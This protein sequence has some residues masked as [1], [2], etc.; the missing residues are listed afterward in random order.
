MAAPPD[1][2]EP[3]GAVALTLPQ[4]LDEVTTDATVGPNDSDYN[5]FCGA[6]ATEGSVW[7]TYTP[8]ADGGVLI[9]VSQSDFEAGVMVFDGT[10]AGD[11]SNLD[12][13]GPDEVGLEAQTGT[14]YYIMAF[15]DTADVPHDNLEISLSSAPTPKAHASLSKKGKAF[16]GGAAELHGSYRCTHDDFG[17]E[18]DV[19]LLQ[20]AGRLKIQAD[21]FTLVQCD[22]KTHHWSARLVSDNGYYAKGKA[23]A[24][25]AII[26]CGVVTCAVGKDK[27]NVKLSWASGSHKR[28]AWMKRPTHLPK[29]RPHALMR[30][31]KPYS[32]GKLWRNN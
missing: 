13:C 29:T 28:P 5:G 21:S 4:T 24:K 12:T 1:N 31:A 19:H 25:I 26:S 22:G 32:P 17:S 11:G 9:D 8:S 23:K 3:E 2:D 30:V 7:F 20:R 27:A 14:T 18:L 15:S 10:P 6:P 16:H